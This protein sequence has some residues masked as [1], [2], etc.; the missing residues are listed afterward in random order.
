[1]GW[2]ELAFG[3][4]FVCCALATAP[5]AAGTVTVAPGI[6]VSKRTYG[7]PLNEEPFYGFRDKTAQQLAADQNLLATVDAAPG[8]EAALQ[9][10]LAR[11]GRAIAAG[12]FAEAARRYNQAY[13]LKPD[14]AEIY[15][16]FAIVA[17]AR[18]KDSAYAEELFA[19]ASRLKPG[20]PA[21][22]ADQ[23]R[24]FLTLR[25]PAEAL[26]LLETVVRDPR[27]GAMHWSNLGFAYAQTGQN[28]KACE[29][30]AKAKGKSPSPGVQSDLVALEK[31]AAC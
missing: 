16:G 1:M 15:H 31:R 29:A 17:D 14:S 3:L 13:L 19:V 2:R 28:A 25:R 22:L 5:L 23:A 7:A 8:R 30:L 26:P 18:F 24:L 10:L 9:G 6:V 11:G 12:D 21:I 4:A 20:D 27:A